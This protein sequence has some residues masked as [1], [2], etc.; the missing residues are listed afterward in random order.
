M[1]LPPW[2]FDAHVV[3]CYHAYVTCIGVAILQCD[4]QVKP[5]VLHVGCMVSFMLLPAVTRLQ[6]KLADD[7]HEYC[8]RSAI[9]QLVSVLFAAG[10][11]TCHC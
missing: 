4:V 6:F 11:M 2:F 1:N 9:V 8:I 5:G 7:S 10:G 3:A